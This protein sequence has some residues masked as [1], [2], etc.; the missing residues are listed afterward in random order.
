MGRKKK[1]VP[2]AFENGGANNHKFTGLYLTMAN[3]KPWL[4]LSASARVVYLALKMEWR[5]VGDTVEVSLSQL[6]E[7]TGIGKRTV[8]RSLQSLEDGGFIKTTFHGG[9]AGGGKTAN[10]YKFIAT[11]A[12]GEKSEQVA[13]MAT[14]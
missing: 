13:K 1:Y 3:S 4:S 7:K 14:D 2:R 9:I 8:Q 11:W 6:A 12:A 10:Q 5:G